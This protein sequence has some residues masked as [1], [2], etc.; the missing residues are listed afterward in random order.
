MYNEIDKVSLKQIEK[1][2]IGRL[3]LR[4]AIEAAADVPPSYLN[5]L[6][7]NGIGKRITMRAVRTADVARKLLNCVED[8]IHEQNPNYQPLN[9][10]RDENTTN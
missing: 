2:A 5:F 1:E 9:E 6:L 8:F 7:V 10:N 4:R 3:K